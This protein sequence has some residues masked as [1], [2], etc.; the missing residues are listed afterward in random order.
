MRS[1]LLTLACLGII[2]CGT[3]P[4][5]DFPYLSQ[6]DAASLVTAIDDALIADAAVSWSSDDGGVH[7]VVI[8]TTAYMDWRDRA[9]REVIYSID[10]GEG[11]YRQTG[12]Y[13]RG[14]DGYWMPD[15]PPGGAIVSRKPQS[16]DDGGAVTDLRREMTTEL[17]R[18]YRKY[19]SRA[20]ARREFRK[21][22]SLQ[23]RRRVGF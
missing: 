1:Y 6:D 13:C 16:P 14:G 19:D 7:G 12:K 23:E 4:P 11:V 22:Y 8:P 10:A 15:V 5:V 3:P 20:E 9:C 21:R 17:R 18:L 2:G